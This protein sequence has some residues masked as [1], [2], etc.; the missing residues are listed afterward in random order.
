MYTL[1]HT[2]PCSN[3]SCSLTNNPLTLD[4]HAAAYTTCSIQFQACM[5]H[6]SSNVIYDCTSNPN[7][8]IH[9]RITLYT[10]QACMFHESSNVIYGRTNNP[11]DRARTPGGSSGGCAV[12]QCNVL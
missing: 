2:L 1:P 5:L 7:G 10:P 3:V 11:H 4:S 9:T 8:P 12:V 6:E